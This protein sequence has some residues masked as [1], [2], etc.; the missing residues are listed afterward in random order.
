VTRPTDRVRENLF[1]ENL[2]DALMA[3]V[4]LRIAELR[5]A[6]PDERERLVDRAGLI[7]LIGSQADTL[8][9]ITKH[10]KA[11]D[12]SVLAALIEGAALLAFQPGG[13]DGLGVHACTGPHPGCP[14][15][16]I[17]Y[18]PASA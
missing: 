12:P 7:Q 5:R 8:M 16:I 2:A 11:G 1:R 15:R 18:A 13:F 10:R 14:G 3:F 17:A 6:T 4:P 9:F